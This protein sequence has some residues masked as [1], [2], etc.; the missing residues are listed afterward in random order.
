MTVLRGLTVGTARSNAV[1]WQESLPRYLIAAV[2]VFLA[3]RFIAVL[4][5]YI[6]LS[7]DGESRSLFD[8]LVRA[9][10][11]GWYQEIA[12]DGYD[13]A[14]DLSP[15]LRVAC[16][17][18]TETGCLPDASD[19]V[20]NLAFFP[21]FPA[22]I[23]AV[24]MV[25]IDPGLAALL[26]AASMSVVAAALIAMLARDFGGPRFGLIAVFLWGCWPANMVLSMGRPESLFTALAAGA[27]LLAARGRLYWAAGVAAVCGL[28]RFQALAVILPVVLAAWRA[29]LRS[30][31]WR[32]AAVASLVAPSGLIA[33]LGFLGAPVGALNGWFAIQ[34]TWGSTADGGSEKARFVL[35]NLWN[36][37]AVYQVA[38]WTLVGACL[39][40][41]AG[42]I[43]RIPWTLSAY[44]AILL[45]GVLS[46]SAYH[47]HIMR[48][49]LVAFP[50]VFP[51]A[52]A[53]RRWP[54]WVVVPTLVVIAVV[55]TAFQTQLWSW[56]WSF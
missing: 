11:G 42:L 36:G 14:A 12:S 2:A 46:Q 48:F 49:L 35:D 10:D 9:G 30:R 8:S 34:R 4:G 50:L 39:L 1:A 51:A 40:F 18:A 33:S 16:P 56:G 17:D 32:V 19:R 52:W 21:L 7:Q 54:G 24:S 6:A 44:T 25:G 55:S 31:E 13:T 41:A 29:G 26:I 23:R 53:A 27:L 45:L 15:E 38:A 5:A 47:Q 22:L 20:S 43:I 3:T 37:D 28:A